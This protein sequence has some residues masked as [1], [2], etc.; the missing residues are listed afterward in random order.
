MESASLIPPYSLC[1]VLLL[2]RAHL[3]QALLNSLFPLRVNV[4]NQYCLKQS[5]HPRFWW[6]E[7][8]GKPNRTNW[9]GGLPQKQ[10]FDLIVCDKRGPL[11]SLSPVPKTPDSCYHVAAITHTHTHMHTQHT[12]FH[13]DG[14]LTSSFF[15]SRSWHF[16]SV[17]KCSC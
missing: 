11:S 8:R 14:H 6:L 1:C 4:I 3:G 5:T 9:S 15:Y 10:N 13:F 2:T 16:L 17:L 12:H 7:S